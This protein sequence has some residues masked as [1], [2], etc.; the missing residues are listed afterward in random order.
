MISCRL[1]SHCPVLSFGLLA[2]S[3][4][5]YAQG[6][7]VEKA[8]KAQLGAATAYYE[9]GVTA[10]D[11]GKVDEALQLFQKSC[12]EVDSPNSHMMLGRALAKLGRLSEAYRELTKSIEQ[13]ANP[14]TTQK[15]YKKTVE[16]AQNELS[17]VKTKLAFVTVKP[18]ASVLIR[19]QD[20]PLS[21]AQ[22]PQPVMPGVVVLDVT[23]SD[24]RK[25]SQQLTLKAGERSE[26]VVQ[27]QPAAVPSQ[28]AT[29]GAMASPVAEPAPT[30]G[31]SR[32][33]VGYIFGAAGVVGVGA[34]VGFGILGASH[35]GNTKA[36]CTA[37]TCP[38]SAVNHEGSKALFQG[39]GYTGLGVGIVGLAAGAW[40]L[41]SHDS[42]YAR[43]SALSLTPAGVKLEVS[44]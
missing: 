33:T 41:L 37:Q 8:T 11:A 16:A 30:S 13:A 4:T 40:L 12:A 27:A 38:E 28:L 22:E 9:R 21:G 34:F 2:A 44:Y 18:G 36:D 24:G 25:T 17:D 43:A 20:E 14:A 3:S 29:S 35:Y 5:V 31:L 26:I 39:I 10:M 32:K 23:F 6:V 19:G 15:K 42:T 1:L 7:A